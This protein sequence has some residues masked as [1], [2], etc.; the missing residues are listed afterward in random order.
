VNGDGILE[1]EELI[2][3]SDTMVS[4]INSPKGIAFSPYD[5]DDYLYISL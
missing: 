3:K 1:T 5:N 4:G 2:V